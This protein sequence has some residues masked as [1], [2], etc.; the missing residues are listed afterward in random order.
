MPD[1]ELL[2]RIGSA[3]KEF[4]VTKLRFVHTADLHLGKPFGGYA[5]ADRLRVVRRSI[6]TRLVEVA[7]SE[8]APDVLVAG[9]LFETPNPSAQTWRQAV[10]EMAEATDVTWWLLPGNHDN[11]AQA[12]TTWEAI[13]DLGHDNV[14]VLFEA[15]PVALK[16]G[17]F[18][19]PAPLLT[20]R[21]VSDPTAWMDDCVTTDGAIRIGL[22]HGPVQGFDEGEMPADIIAPDRDKRAGLDYLALG[23]WHGMT[24]VSDRVRY[25]G[26]PESTDFRHDGRGVCLVVE[27]EGPGLSPKVSEV[28]TGTFDW[29]TISLNLVPGDD[30]DVM[31]EEKLPKTPRRDMLVKVVASGRIPLRDA[32]ALAAMETGI[33]PDFCDFRVNM[34]DLGIEV[35]VADLDAIALGGALRAASNALADEAHDEALSERDRNIAEAALRRLHAIVVEDGV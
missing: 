25:S 10:A 11:L 7:R 4:T 17:A 22:A 30:P 12:R 5:E 20:R 18:L 15:E 8:M 6:I 27:I 16:E 2:A 32:S 9:D 35:E 21:P 33:G 24:R 26:A 29:R 3:G 1:G 14:R 34:A 31:L 23:D 19:L 28:E 13:R